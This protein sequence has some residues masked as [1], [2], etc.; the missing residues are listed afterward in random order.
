MQIERATTRATLV[1]KLLLTWEYPAREVLVL[2]SS[3]A[4]GDTSW[5]LG[6]AEARL[7]AGSLVHL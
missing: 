7:L 1:H 2:Y 3:Y 5:E 4:A 6:D